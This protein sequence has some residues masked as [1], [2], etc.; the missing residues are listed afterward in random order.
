MN[1]YSLVVNSDLKY[2]SVTFPEAPFNIS[3][4]ESFQGNNTIP[5]R[6]KKKN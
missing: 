5:Q 1:A 4:R 3:G 6:K 2:V